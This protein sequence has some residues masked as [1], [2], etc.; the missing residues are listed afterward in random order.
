M[1]DQV[2]E[3]L[4]EDENPSVRYFTLV[5]LLHKSPKNTEVRK[6]RQTIMNT[7]VVPAIL[8]QQNEGVWGAPGR[9]Y[10]DK[11]KGTSW[12]IL[13]LAEMGADPGDQRIGNA[14]EFILQHSQDPESGGFSYDT[15]AKTGT[16]LPSGVV[17]CLTG[18]MV[19]S[20]IKLGYLD[21]GRVQKA[22]DWIIKYQRADDAVDEGPAGKVYER[23]EMCWGR[24]SCHM[25]VA[26]SLKAL[27]AVPPEKRT[28]AINAK[29]DELLEYFLKHHL[30]K[31]SHN[32]EQIARPGWLRLGFP[33]MYQTDILELLGICADLAK[34]DP[35]LLDALAIVKSKRGADGK[36]KLENT[37]NG[38][39]L[40]SIEKKGQPSKW[41]TLKA[42]KALQVLDQ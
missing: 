39:T 24:H 32:L 40:V 7:G 18:N 28:P 4:L 23:Y 12:N 41:I 33:L 14:C 21:D 1:P 38:K 10:R 19:Y 11:Y 42:L 5:S 37:F 16:G 25:G 30:Y 22:I 15:S 6:A 31:K 36:W 34:N 26:K 17:P 3:W 27:A 35:R 8:Q 13:I 20:L 2:I 9:F 29:I